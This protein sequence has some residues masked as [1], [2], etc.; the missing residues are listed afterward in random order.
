[1]QQELSAGAGAAASK[2]IMA[3][4]RRRNG[5]ISVHCNLAVMP[6]SEALRAIY[7]PKSAIVFDNLLTRAGAG[8]HRRA[9]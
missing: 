3:G 5:L 4:R 6:G 8:R 2:A 1:M 7:G 9:Q